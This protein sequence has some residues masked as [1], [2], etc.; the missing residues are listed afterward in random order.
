[1]KVFVRVGV[2]PP[3][4]FVVIVKLVSAHVVLSVA[5]VVCLCVIIVVLAFVSLSSVLVAAWS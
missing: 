5:V 2:H 4:A 1:V 3:P